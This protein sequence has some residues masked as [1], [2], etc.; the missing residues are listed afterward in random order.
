MWRVGQTDKPIQPARMSFE[1]SRSFSGM[2]LPSRESR[3]KEVP[4]TEERGAERVTTESGSN[5]DEAAKAGRSLAFLIDI[6]PFE[7]FSIFSVFGATL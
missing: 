7:S 4:R 6:R 3:W 2:S 1:S 5:D